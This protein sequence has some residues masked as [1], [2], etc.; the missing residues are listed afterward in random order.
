MFF[1]KEPKK[2][3]A[4]IISAINKVRDLSSDE[5]EA[6]KCLNLDKKCIHFKII[7]FVNILL[8]LSGMTHL[9]CKTSGKYVVKEPTT[10]ISETKTNPKLA[11]KLLHFLICLS[12]S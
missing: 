12:N 5:S 11:K 9:A 4:T 7:T 6:K 2:N 3:L 1:L 10:R 8:Y